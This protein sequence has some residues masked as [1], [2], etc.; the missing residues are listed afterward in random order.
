MS[1]KRVVVFNGPPG[2]GKDHAAEYI[3]RM[4]FKSMRRQFKD[5][6]FKVTAAIFAVPQHN[7]EHTW[8]TRELK[9]QPREELNGFSPREALIYVSEHIIKPN[10]GSRYFGEALAKQLQPG[11]TLVSDSGFTEELLP[12]IEEVGHE[13]I[14]VVRV[15][16]RGSYEGD[17]RSYIPVTFM[18]AHGV[19]FIDIE[20]TG[21]IEEFEKRLTMSVA[22]GWLEEKRESEVA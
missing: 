20:N 6:L 18:N 15:F 16:G 21:T 5:Q 22:L 19:E 4:F 11:L 10:M 3:W 9:E 14:L 12:V 17:S 7:L 8:Y 13:N 2:C 1:K